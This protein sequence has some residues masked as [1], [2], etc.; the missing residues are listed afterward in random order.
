MQ[1]HRV[2]N[3]N[4]NPN[5]CSKFKAESIGYLY[6]YSGLMDALEQGRYRKD[7][8][9]LKAIKKLRNDGMN[10]EYKYVIDTNFGYRDFLEIHNHSTGESQ[11][12]G[13]RNNIEE[14]FF[15]FRD[16]IV[17]I[18]RQKG[19]IE[20]TPVGLKAI[21][22]SYYMYP[23]VADAKKDLRDKGFKIQIP[24]IEQ[25]EDVEKALIQ[26]ELKKLESLQ[27]SDIESNEDA[28]KSIQSKINSIIN[29]KIEEEYRVFCENPE[30]LSK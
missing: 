29:Q 10:D 11:K 9:F 30:I 20:G 12:Y 21:C 22:K 23:K 28:I 25:V 6:R 2:Q 3:N 17:D 4:L 19:L 8:T 27:T 24:K 14:S 16:M 13:L 7:G 15:M 1:V 26:D 18:A 5:F